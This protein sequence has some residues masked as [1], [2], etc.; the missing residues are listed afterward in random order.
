MFAPPYSTRR[1]RHGEANAPTEG[2][3]AVQQNINFA[4]LGADVAAWQEHYIR[5]I[6]DAHGEDQAAATAADL[7]ADPWLAL[8]WFV[9]DRRA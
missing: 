1:V 3:D 9:E 7:K 5:H 2:Q 4:N 6:M 8:Q